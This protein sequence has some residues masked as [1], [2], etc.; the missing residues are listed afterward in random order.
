MQ[1]LPTPRHEL[2]EQEQAAELQ[3]SIA[4]ANRWKKIGLISKQKPDVRIDCQIKTLMLK[5]P[6][7][8]ENILPK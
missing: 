7:G 3:A 1:L 8:S 6:F 5:T 4:S 2:A